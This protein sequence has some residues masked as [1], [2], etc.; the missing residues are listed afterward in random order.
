MAE[1]GMY[2]PVFQKLDRSG[3][4]PPG[5]VLVCELPV[6]GKYIDAVSLSPSGILTAF[7][8]K[9]GSGTRAMRQADLNR[10]YV[11]RSYVVLGRPPSPASLAVADATGVGVLYYRVT[12][13][14][15]LR[16]AKATLSRRSEVPVRGRTLEQVRDLGS[17]LH[18]AL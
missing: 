18:D 14:R 5:T 3:Q 17:R 10:H 1:L 13:G 15:L 11:D 16:L 8:L 2:A 7:E 6:H 12:D 9:F 4:L